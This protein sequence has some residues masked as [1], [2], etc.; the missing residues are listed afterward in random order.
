MIIIFPKID[1]LDVIPIDNPVVPKADATSTT[2]E[3]KL[4]FSVTLKTKTLKKHN[5]I[6]RFRTTIDFFTSSL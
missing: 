4:C 5:A 3:T 2:N 6:E 1:K